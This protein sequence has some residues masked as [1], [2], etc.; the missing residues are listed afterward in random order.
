VFDKRK[1]RGITM[2]HDD[3][4][5]ITRTSTG[6]DPLT[7]KSIDTPQTLEPYKCRLGK[8]TGSFIQMQPQGQVVQQLRIYI[9]DVNADIKKGDIGVLNNTDKYII[10]NVYKPNKHHIE[11]DVTCK[12]DV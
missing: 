6:K 10:G 12:E 2:R 3:T 8:V 4:L 1:K 7:H 5:V 11:A 9:P